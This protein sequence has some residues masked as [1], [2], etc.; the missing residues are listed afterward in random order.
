MLTGASGVSS[1]GFRTRNGSGGFS[2]SSRPPADLGGGPLIVRSA[3]PAED[4]RVTSHAGQLLSL[5]VPERSGFADAVR[6]VVA[7]LP[8]DGDG[9]PAGAV[10]VQ[11]L[12]A[13]AEAGVAFFD[14]F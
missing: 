14:G 10:F 5:I 13:A 9:K 6:R 1:A 8:R 3:S 7:A 4:G 2:R 11:P 12:V